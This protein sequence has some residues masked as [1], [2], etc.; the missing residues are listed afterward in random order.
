[1]PNGITKETFENMESIEDRLSV[2][3]DLITEIRQQVNKYV[4]IWGLI[5]GAVPSVV[6]IIVLVLTKII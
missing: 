3:F 5:G 2:L 1:M 4:K 6:I